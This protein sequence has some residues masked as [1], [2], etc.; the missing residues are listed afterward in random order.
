MHRFTQR[1]RGRFSSQRGDRHALSS[2][3][4]NRRSH[5]SYAEQPRRSSAPACTLTIS[6]IAVRAGVSK[7]T[8]R[9]ALKKAARLGLLTTEEQG[10]NLAVRIISREWLEWVAKG[11]PQAQVEQFEPDF[12]VMPLVS[13]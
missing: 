6:Q 13:P 2:I 3:T 10:P 8:V 5:M 11:R 1:Q 12:G 7:N 9:K 4:G